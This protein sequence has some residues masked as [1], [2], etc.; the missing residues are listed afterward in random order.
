ME[1]TGRVSDPLSPQQ[2][3]ENILQ[4]LCDALRADVFFT[5][6]ASNLSHITLHNLDFTTRH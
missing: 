5:I 2:G 6:H 4:W 3:V 1:P